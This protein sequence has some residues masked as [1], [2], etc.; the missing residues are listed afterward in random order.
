V[1]VGSSLEPSDLAVARVRNAA[2]LGGPPA[3]LVAAIAAWLLASA[4][5]RPVERMRRQA[6]DISEHDP[7]TS[8]EVPATRD[9]IAAL[10]RTMNGLLGRLQDALARERGFVADA[11]HELRTP[12]AILRAELELASRPGRTNAELAQAV[13]AAAEETDRLARLAEDLLSLA[14]TDEGSTHIHRERAELGPLLAATVHRASAKATELGVD[15]EL[16]VDQGLV[17]DVDADRVRQALTNLIDNALRHAPRSSAVRVAATR[18]G[19]AV[20][21]EVADAGPG[22][23]L[24]FLPHAFERFRRAD[25]ARSRDGGGAGLGLAIV[26]SIAEAHG[27]TATAANLTTGG[28]VVRIEL[29][30]SRPNTAE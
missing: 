7:D 2:V 25:A 17:V 13:S 24:S 9:E 20:V 27:G 28:A 23:P 1:V 18:S 10:A 16:V 30:A 19:D 8:I 12:L 3:V 22:F 6:A 15:L 11:G 4:A 21:M 5:L 14:R 29:P 26:R